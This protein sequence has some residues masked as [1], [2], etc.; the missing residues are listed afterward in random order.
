[1]RKIVIIL[2]ILFTPHFV[3]QAHQTRDYFAIGGEWLIVLLVLL[4]IYGLVPAV[5][6][7]VRQCLESGF[8]KSIKNKM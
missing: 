4:V 3:V 6:G 2:A 7:L 1:M 8:R 5:V